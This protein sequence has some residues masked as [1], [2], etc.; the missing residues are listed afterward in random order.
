MAS[1]KHSGLLLSHVRAVEGAMDSWFLGPV[2]VC[3]CQC[4]VLVEGQPIAGRVGVD[5]GRFEQLVSA[6]SQAPSAK[7]QSGAMSRRTCHEAWC[8]VHSTSNLR[9]SCRD[10]IG[11]EVQL[12]GDEV[13][14]A[15]LVACL[16]AD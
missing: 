11:E 5:V 10:L 6:R 1:R 3:Q 13:K 16:Q 2:L 4:F 14:G 8:V 12:L 9:Y 7:Q 15:E